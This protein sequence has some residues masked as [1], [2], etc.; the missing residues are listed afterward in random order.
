MNYLLHTMVRVE[1]YGLRLPEVKPGDDL[2]R[3]IVEG[4][5]REAGGLRDGD[6][7]V[8]ASKVVSKS[9][10][11]LIDMRRVKPSK[12]ALRIARKTGM[13]PRMVQA[14]LENCDRVL[15]LIPIKL[16]AD[17]FFDGFM[18]LAENPEN[19][20]RAL[21]L[22][23]YMLVVRRGLQVYTDAGLDFSNHP[24]N[25]ASIPPENPDLY[26]RKLRKRI[27]ELSG[28]DV[29][30]VI[31]DT[32]CFPGIGSIDL[33]RG[34][35]GIEVVSRRFGALDR[36]GKPKFGGVDRVADQ[37]ASAAALLMGQTAE[38]IPVVLVRGL[39]YVRREEG[40]LD[41]TLEPE[42][43]KHIFRLI[44]RENIRVLGL[45]CLLRLIA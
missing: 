8:I 42:A 12:K 23:P 43:V 4:A 20:R 41:H 18:K 39:R 35:S 11:L 38:G 33:A 21:E 15:F 32:E 14:V 1:L 36:F 17:R 10:G 24:E 22:I 31:S 40:V 3:L 13:N 45:R 26:A 9:Y 34:S 37:L 28:M 25:V 6:V 19:A 30:V 5:S 16:I 7:L 2:A 27:K 29:A 44:L